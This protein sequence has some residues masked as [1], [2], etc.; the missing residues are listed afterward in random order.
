MDVVATYNEV[1]SK[2][3]NLI[4]RFSTEGTEQEKKDY[5]ERGM[6]K[7]VS[8]IFTLI[9]IERKLDSFVATKFEFFYARNLV[10]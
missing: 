9:A 7:V 6:R 2:M 3:I 1:L 5:E 10:Q 8:L 4:S